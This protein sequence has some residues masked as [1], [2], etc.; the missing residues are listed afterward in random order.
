MARHA[1]RVVAIERGRR[2]RRRARHTRRIGGY[3]G[4][5]PLKL[6]F[7]AAQD[8]R[9]LVAE[10]DHGVS[11]TGPSD[12]VST[13]LKAVIKSLIRSWNTRRS[14]LIDGAGCQK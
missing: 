12:M 7:R 13:R 5:S 2:R 6:G 8:D 14:R 10:V 1:V 11:L 9:V 3:R 4:D